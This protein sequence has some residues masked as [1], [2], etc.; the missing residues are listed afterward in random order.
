MRERGTF[1]QVGTAD[2][3]VLVTCAAYKMSNSRVEPRA[4]LAA[5]GEHTQEVMRERFGMSESTF[6]QLRTA[7]AFGPRLKEGTSA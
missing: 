4:T 7:G 2:E 6:A 5:L 1:K 3:P